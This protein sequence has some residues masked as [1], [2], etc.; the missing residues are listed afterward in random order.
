M[1]EKGPKMASGL[2]AG[3]W[4]VVHGETAETQVEAVVVVLLL[5]NVDPCARPGSVATIV[6]YVD[7]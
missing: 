6:G 1:S 2:A 4:V 3:W 5:A 7:P